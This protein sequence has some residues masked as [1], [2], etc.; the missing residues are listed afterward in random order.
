MGIGE[1]L[2]SRHVPFDVLL[3]G[4]APSAS[5]RAH[6]VH[7]SGGRVSKAVLVKAGTGYVLAVVPATHRIDLEKLSGVIHTTGLAI[8]TE[9]E[10]EA[11]FTDCERGAV[12][13]FGSRYNLR[14][15]V[16]ASLAGGSEIVV[17]G[18]VRHEGFRVR[19][20][21]FEQVECPIKAR[22]AELV[23]PRRRKGSDRRAG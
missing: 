4:P 23:A 18:N 22:F 2:R 8:A 12:P 10:L 19:F 21:D 5:H 15:I 13:P 1:F 3:H 16:D 17:D 6:N 20:R 14:T 7:I 9:D 11:V